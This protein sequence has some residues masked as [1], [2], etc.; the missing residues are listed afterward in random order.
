[1]QS[2]LFSWSV[3]VALALMCQF[4]AWAT[5]GFVPSATENSVKE[6]TCSRPIQI[7]A[8]PIGRSMIISPEGNISG[9]TKAFFD[10][11]EKDTACVFEYVIVP[12]ARAWHMLEGAQ[13]DLVA[14]A[15]RSPERDRAAQFLAV[16]KSRPVL[17]SLPNRVLKPKTIEELINSPMTL[18]TFTGHFWGQAYL[19][20]L[21][22]PKMQGRISSV[23]SPEIAIKMLMRGRADA[24]LS[25]Q[26]VIFDAWENAGNGGKLNT[27]EIDGLPPLS[28]GMYMSWNKMSGQDR[29]LIE[30]ATLARIKSGD[31]AKTIND[32]YPT[33]AIYH[34]KPT[35]TTTK[36]TG[37]R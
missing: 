11:I 24:I 2:T 3:L 12:R 37:K 29:K 30:S 7:A 14:D 9:A 5:Q 19:D 10:L 34:E 31:L 15:T 16:T 13:I 35:A 27:D 4:S 36:K 26:A 22:N 21:S 33:W 25:G 1:M 32:Y 6:A 18:I 8:S 23:P 28:V 17:I 20:L